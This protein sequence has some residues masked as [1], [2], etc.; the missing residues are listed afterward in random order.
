MEFFHIF[1][2]HSYWKII[3]IFVPFVIYP[4]VIWKLQISLYFFPE[5]NII[6]S[7]WFHFLIS[8]SSSPMWN[9]MFIIQ[10]V[11]ID[12]WVYFWVFFSTALV[13]LCTNTTLIWWL[14]FNKLLISDNNKTHLI[15]MYI[16]FLFV[17]LF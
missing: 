14:I 3:L 13:Y 1:I 6:I 9:S 2:C 8:L 4:G 5:D 10:R 7:T 16:I 11:I 12:I 17:C 15:Y